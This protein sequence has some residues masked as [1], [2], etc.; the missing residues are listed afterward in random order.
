MNRTQQGLAFA[1][2]TAAISGVAVFVN[3]GGVRAFGDATAYTTA[4]NLAAA[5][6]QHGQ[7]TTTLAKAKDAMGLLP[8]R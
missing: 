6:F 1:G 3:S 7:I 2:G 5:L 4:K 8:A